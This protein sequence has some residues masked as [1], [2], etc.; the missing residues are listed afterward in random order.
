MRSDMDFTPVTLMN[1]NGSFIQIDSEKQTTGNTKKASELDEIESKRICNW[2]I[3]SP[4][5][6][7]EVINEIIERQAVNKVYAK[8]L[9]KIWIN[10][11][12]IVK[13]KE[14]KYIVK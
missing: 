6:Y 8:Q 10:K 14:N 9:I 11:G 5:Y 13:N 7:D 1:V 12:W 4:L 3:L 2:I